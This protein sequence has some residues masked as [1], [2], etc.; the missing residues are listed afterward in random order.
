MENNSNQKLEEERHVPVCED[1]NVGASVGLGCVSDGVCD[2][3]IVT[4]FA[5]REQQRY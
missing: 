2:G 3:D 4:T 5:R 1:I